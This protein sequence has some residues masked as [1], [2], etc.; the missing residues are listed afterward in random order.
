MNVRLTMMEKVK[1]KEEQEHGAMLYLFVHDDYVLPNLYI[2]INYTIPRNENHKDM[3]TT[4][5]S[6]TPS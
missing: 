3:V 4:Q 2:L 5:Y 6:E 1:G